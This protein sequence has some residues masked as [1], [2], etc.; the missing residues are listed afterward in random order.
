MI[1]DSARL[2]GQTVDGETI[3][4][5]AT[6]LMP[7][8]VTQDLLGIAPG[9]GSWDNLLMPGVQLDDDSHSLLLCHVSDTLARSR[10]NNRTLSEKLEPPRVTGAM[11]T[12]QVDAS[13]DG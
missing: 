2:T 13:K 9:S 3:E 6:P 4:I 7:L 12:L 11:V 1:T 5:T 8:S 10:D